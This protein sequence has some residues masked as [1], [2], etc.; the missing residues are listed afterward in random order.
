[1]LSYLSGSVI[2]GSSA[3][4]D[5]MQGIPMITGGENYESLVYGMEKVK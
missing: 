3:G 1:L 5:I 2:A 4:C